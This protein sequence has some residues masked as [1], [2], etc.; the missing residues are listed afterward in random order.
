MAKSRAIYAAFDIYPSYKGAATHIGHMVDALST[1]FEALTVYSLGSGNNDM[2]CNQE[3]IKYEHFIPDEPN[4]LKRANNYVEWLKTR[5]FDEDIIDLAHFRDV[6]SALA[7]LNHPGVINTI[8]EVNAFLPIEL[9]YRYPGITEKT[10]NR[11]D[12]LEKQCLEECDLIICPS[13]V[14]KENL[15]K[16]GVFEHKINVLPNGADVMETQTSE[17]VHGDQNEYIIYFGAIQPWQGVDQLIKAMSYLKDYP[18]LKLLIVSSQ[19]SR[20]SKSLQ[21]VAD[22]LLLSDRIEWHFL[23]EKEDLYKL[24]SNALISV[25][26]LTECSRNLDQGCSPIKIFESMANGTAVL[27]TDLP[28]TRE[29]I[30]DKENGMLV[31]PDR[32]AELARGIRLLLDNPELRTKLASNGRGTIRRS[33]N[34]TEIKGKLIGI[35]RNILVY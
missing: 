25:A 6:W 16:R 20:Y 17:G 8:Y 32:P 9:P 34:W 29:I 26:P 13:N 3:G 14:I 18:D 19:K 11:I 35:Y 10:L 30:V 1:E 5:I 12:A 2:G 15:K 31:R 24:I 23:V 7:I 4:Y 22:K 33:Y 28:V 21:K 27:T